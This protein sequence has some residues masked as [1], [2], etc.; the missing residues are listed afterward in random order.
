[1]RYWALGVLFVSWCSSTPAVSQDEPESPAAP[2]PAGA[3]D[4][5]IK[6]GKQVY[7]RFC[8]TCH[9]MDGKGTP[10]LA[11]NLP[12]PPDL[13]DA[14]WTHGNTDEAILAVIRDGTD[15]GMEAYKDR[16]NEQRLGQLVQY[17]KSLGA[18]G[19]AA[20]TAPV[21][22]VPQNPVAAS[23]ESVKRGMQT[24]RRFC[25]KCHGANGKGDTEMV[26][27]LSTSPSDLTDGKWKYGEQDGNIF[28]IIRDG[29]PYD[30]ESFKD[31][32]GDEDMWHIVNYM[33]SL[34]PKS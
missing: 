14:E 21:D 32:L 22:D 28:V 27:F 1:M 13:T 26:E 9:G 19:E 34:E 30:M 12:I 23:A 11:K 29:T 4:A 7:Q 18:G 3:P 6:A 15:K 31:R 25:V 17:V 5:A 16:L 8:V 33:R 24:Y 10:D 2:N 20:A